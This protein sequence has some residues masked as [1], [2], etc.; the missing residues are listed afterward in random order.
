MLATLSRWRPRVQIPS[1]PLRLGSS[2]GT[3]VRL[4]SGRSPVRP[5]PQPPPPYQGKHP[6]RDLEEWKKLLSDAGVREARLH[7]ARHTAATVLLILGVPDRTVMDFMGWSTI[8][9]KQRYMHVT[10]DIRRDLANQ[11]NA[12]F[13]KA[14]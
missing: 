1:G 11:L 8:T 6:R 13:W 10:E 4:K 12:Y 2:V 3:S 5:R 9:M 7:D 14:G